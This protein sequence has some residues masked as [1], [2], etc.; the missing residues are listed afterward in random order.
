MQQ[1]ERVVYVC[2]VQAVQGELVGRLGGTAYF[3]KDEAVCEC[4]STG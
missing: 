1:I 3:E 2:L 4:L